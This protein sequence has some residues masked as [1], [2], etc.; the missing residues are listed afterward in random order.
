MVPPSWTLLATVMAHQVS[1][2]L[3]FALVYWS[4]TFSQWLLVVINVQRLVALY[5]PGRVRRWTSGRATHMQI[6]VVAAYST[7]LLATPVLLAG[8]RS[9]ADERRCTVIGA[10]LHEDI[11]PMVYLLH[12]LLAYNNKMIYP[13]VVNAVLIA[14][15]LVRLFKY[16]NV[17]RKFK[18]S[19]TSLMGHSRVELMNTMNLMLLAIVQTVSHFLTG[20]VGTI[21]F[22]N[23]FIQFLN[24][25]GLAITMRLDFLMESFGIAAI[26]AT[27][28]VYYWRIRVFRLAFWRLLSCGLVRRDLR[29]ARATASCQSISISSHHCH[30]QHHFN[31]RNQRVTRSASVGGRGVLDFDEMRSARN[32]CAAQVRRSESACASRHNLC[33]GEELIATASIGHVSKR[34]SLK[35]GAVDSLVLFSSLA[36]RTQRNEQQRSSNICS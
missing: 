28:V 8:G 20:C 36:A 26:V 31:L 9:V 27:L 34:L 25:T 24:R 22:L 10:D 2:K 35:L 12:T 3:V 5:F 32:T 4:D 21:I 23:S 14:L 33:Y 6:A 18:R 17:S 11:R 7:L 19:P 30:H 29:D 1:C 13:T 16:I 15:I